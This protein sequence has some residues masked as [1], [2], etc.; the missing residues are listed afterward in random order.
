MARIEE[1]ALDL[2]N[3]AEAIVS[4]LH[5]ATDAFLSHTLK[6]STNLYEKTPFGMHLIFSA[7][8]DRLEKALKIIEKG[9]K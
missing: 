2:I 5:E 6:L 8:E 4:F 9:G 1:N 7:V 3:E